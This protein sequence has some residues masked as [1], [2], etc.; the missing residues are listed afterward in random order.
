MLEG[1][2]SRGH[3]LEAQTIAESFVAFQPDVPID[4][5]RLSYPKPYAEIV[6]SIAEEYGIDP[7]LVWA[8]RLG[9][10]SRST[11]PAGARSQP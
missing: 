9:E 7:L 5:L 6:L 8:T 10:A 4:F 2:I 1:L 3:F 11:K